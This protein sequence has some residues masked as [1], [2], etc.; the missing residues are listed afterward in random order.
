VIRTIRSEQ[1]RALPLPAFKA[2]VREQFLMLLVD[3]ERA[4]ATLPELVAGE[5]AEASRA[6][7]AIE[8]VARAHGELGEE[9]EARLR[10]TR[11][12]FGDAG[13]KG[14]RKTA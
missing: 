2:L 14:G 10:R 8:Q 1:E 9:A 5:A 12:I 11:E 4:I 3:E 13:G 7:G 6:F